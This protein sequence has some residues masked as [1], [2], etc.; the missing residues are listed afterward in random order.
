MAVSGFETWPYYYG[1]VGDSLRVSLPRSI[2]YRSDLIIDESKMKVSGRE[3]SLVVLLQTYWQWPQGFMT[4]A[5]LIQ[6]GLYHRR[7]RNGSLRKGN[8]PG[9]I[10]H[11]LGGNSLGMVAVKKMTPIRSDPSITTQPI[12]LPKQRVEH[13]GSAKRRGY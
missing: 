7:I 4:P 9:C 6:I 12:V 3:T 10:W 2:L 13:I 8:L 11:G 1:L 5:D